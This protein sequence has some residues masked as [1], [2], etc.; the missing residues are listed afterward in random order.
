MKKLQYIIFFAIIINNLYSCKKGEN[1]PFF[2]IRSRTGRLT[3]DWQLTSFSEVS[4]YTYTGGKST[5]VSTFNGSTLMEEHTVEPWIGGAYIWS[6]VKTLIDEITFE[7]NGTFKMKRTE[8]LGSDIYIKEGQ[9]NWAFLDKSKN[10]DLRNKEAISLFFTNITNSENGY[11]NE[12]GEHG[13][14]SG[15]FENSATLI[16]DQLKNNEVVFVYDEKDTHFNSNTN[17]STSTAGK[18]TYSKK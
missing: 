8:T 17:D 1:D 10:A 14:Y 4:V 7:K 12:Y 11:F 18:M 15:T 16:I 5:K 3:G 6:S 9:G 2:A 13:K